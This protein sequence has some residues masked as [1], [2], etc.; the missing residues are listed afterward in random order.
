MTARAYRLT[1]K[2]EDDTIRIYLG[3]LA[4]FGPKQADQYHNELTG[5]FQLLALNPKMAKERFELTP[6][7]RIHPHKAHVVVYLEEE[8]EILIV[9]IRHG[10]E[11]WDQD[12]L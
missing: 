10:H 2:A 1:R 5:L 6:P 7:V 11:D 4:R 12:P 3:G 8:D 9:R